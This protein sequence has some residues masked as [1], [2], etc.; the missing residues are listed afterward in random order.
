M[1]KKKDRGFRVRRKE[2][3]IKIKDEESGRRE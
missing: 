2:W 1:G 3:E